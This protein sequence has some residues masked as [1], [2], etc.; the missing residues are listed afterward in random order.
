MQVRWAASDCVQTY[1]IGTFGGQDELMTVHRFP[2]APAASPGKLLD[3]RNLPAVPLTR[4]NAAS[5]RR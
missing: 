5:P 1:R 4:Y 2:A 3:R